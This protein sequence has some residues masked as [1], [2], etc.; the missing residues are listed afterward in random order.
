MTTNEERA[1]V[2][3]LR[4]LLSRHSLHGDIPADELDE[5]LDAHLDA[6]PDHQAEA[7]VDSLIRYVRS[8]VTDPK[9]G[10]DPEWIEMNL[11]ADHMR[12]VAGADHQAEAPSDSEA[13]ALIDTWLNGSAI[14][15]P[16][17]PSEVE[18][19]LSDVRAL[20]ARDLAA[21]PVV[22]DAAARR[23]ARA[24]FSGYVGETPGGF[25]KPTYAYDREKSEHVARRA[26]TAALGVVFEQT[27]QLNE[28]EQAH[29]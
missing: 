16:W 3:K 21:R 5:L 2:K 22:D 26:L 17:L 29:G 15:E 12:R 18:T 1:L 9:Y 23:A 25:D 28:Q 11:G 20:V 7:G 6:A 8:V 4:A 14:R 24:I 19:L 10:N 27:H 13:L